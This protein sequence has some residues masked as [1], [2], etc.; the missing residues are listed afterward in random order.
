MKRQIV[1]ALAAALALTPA[2]FCNDTGTSSLGVTIGAEASFSAAFSATTLNHTGTKFASFSGTTNFSYKVRTGQ[3]GGSGAIT[4]EVTDFATGG[5]A[6]ADL[7]YTCSGASSGSPCSSSTAASSSST[8]TVA[9]FGEDAHS[10]DAGDAGSVTW[11]LVDRTDTKTG[12]YSST[13]TFTI[14]AT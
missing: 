12:V 8:T 5:P 11:T 9:T 6:V 1:L 3:S 2:A 13:A 10:A 14:S 7:S 4:V